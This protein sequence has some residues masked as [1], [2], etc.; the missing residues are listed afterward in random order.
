VSS[1]PADEPLAIVR[2]AHGA[3]SDAPELSSKDVLTA[4]FKRK[5]GIAAIAF[6][7]AA[8]VAVVTLLTPKVYE[9][10]AT[11]LVKFG[12][13]YVVRPEVG[14]ERPL[15]GITSEEV[16]NSE[17]QIL[18]SDDLVRAVVQQ[19][20]ADRLFPK[21]S[22]SFGDDGTSSADRAT[23]KALKALSV[24]AVRRSSV[25]QIAFEHREPQLAGEFV[26]ELLALY[27]DKRLE[28]FSGAKSDFAEVQLGAYEEE[29]KKQ[30]HRLENFRQKHGV[31]VY[32]Q[33]MEMLLRRQSELDAQR[34]DAAVRLGELRKSIAS[35]QRELART[36]HSPDVRGQL[37]RDVIRMSADEES[38]RS[39]EA[40]VGQLL[41]NIEAEIRTLDLNERELQVIQRDRAEAERNFQ[42]FRAKAEEQRLASSLDQ[43]KVSNVSVIQRATAPTKRVKPRVAVNVALGVVLGVLTGL[44]YA[45][46][47]EYLSQSM[48]TPQAVERRLQLPVLA[49]VAHRRD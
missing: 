39:R 49:T 38:F 30:E 31:F 9:A 33:Q 22:L 23:R 14:Q 19:I 12:R 16:L 4:L 47:A 1:R 41:R 17:V 45:A 11:I 32:A 48:S 10:R 5:A 25:I 3:A 20:G 18:T 43:M 34:R 8:V 2:P 6:A 28:V 35:I 13:E 37:Q 26:N 15:V 44:L 21:S 42:A 29:L 7:V 40:S 27:Q 46:A 36:S 24:E